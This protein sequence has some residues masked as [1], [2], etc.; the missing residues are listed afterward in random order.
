MSG[1][2]PAG[3]ETLEPFAEYWGVEGSAN[4][5]KRRSGSSEPEREAFYAAARG[6]IPQ[7]LQQLD[8]K[9]LAEHD[10]RERRLLNLTLAFAHVSQAVEMLGKAEPRHARF[11]E[12]MRIT[13]SPADI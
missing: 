12:A 9:P 6:L 13:R 1:L 10:E 3:Y 4:R 8:R 2:L 5:D 7:A 11:R